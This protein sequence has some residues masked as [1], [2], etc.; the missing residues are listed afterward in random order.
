MGALFQQMILEIKRIANRT[1]YPDV[2]ARIAHYIQ[3][4]YHENIEII[5]SKDIYI[6]FEGNLL[7]NGRHQGRKAG[8]GGMEHCFWGI[9]IGGTKTTVGL[10]DERAAK[11]TSMTMPTSAR[12]GFQSLIERI[13]RGAEELRKA[14]EIPRDR[15][16]WAGVACPGPLDLDKGTI[17]YIPTM[18]FRDAPLAASLQEVL[19]TPV[20]LESDTNAA[21][22]GECVFGKGKGLSTAVYITVST[23]VGCGIAVDGRIVDGGRFAAGE[24]GHMKTARGGPHLFLRRPRLSGSLCV[25]NSAG[26]HRHPAD[27]SGNGRQGGLRRRPPGGGALRGHCPPSGR[28]PGISHWRGLSAPGSGYRDSGGQRDEGF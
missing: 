13:G 14:Q 3:S 22:L 21:V 17:V 16:F 8:R 25:G 12:E 10:F 2:V 28:S 5:S 20:S 6:D 27:R 4:T 26:G 19:G 9:D 15:I 7:Y 18:G 24:L 23:G 11:L 1:K